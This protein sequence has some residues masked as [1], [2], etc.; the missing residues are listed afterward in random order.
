MRKV[1]VV[2]VEVE[3]GDQVADGLTGVTVA[4]QIVECIRQDVDNAT[5][6][7]DPGYY[8]ISWSASIS[9]A[10]DI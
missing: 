6:N 2:C 4:D 5:K 3:G 1:F 10:S 7:A 8:G 9:E